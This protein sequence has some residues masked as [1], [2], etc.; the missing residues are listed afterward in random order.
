MEYW[1]GEALAGSQV[2]RPEED[3]EEGQEGLRT[4]TGWQVEQVPSQREP[5]P[6]LLR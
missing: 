6:T 1:A 5:M 2:Q 3:E 4:G